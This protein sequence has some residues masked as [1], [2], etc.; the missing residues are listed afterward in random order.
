MILIYLE[1]D[2]NRM[3]T[4]IGKAFTFK[5]KTTKSLR[6]Q[7]SIGLSIKLQGIFFT[8]L[9]YNCYYVLMISM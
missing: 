3:V 4:F 6:S 1:H 8:V 9:K 7:F 5:K 2:E